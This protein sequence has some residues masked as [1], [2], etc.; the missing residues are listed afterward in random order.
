MTSALL[1]HAWKLKVFTT[2]TYNIDPSSNYGQQP[3]TYAGILTTHWQTLSSFVNIEHDIAP[4]PGAIESLFTCNEP[5]CY[6][7]YPSWPRGT[8]QSGI[9]CVKFGEE[10]LAQYT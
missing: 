2:T 1:K 7:K 8:M 6:Y 10:L 4:W 5:F 3:E 9:G